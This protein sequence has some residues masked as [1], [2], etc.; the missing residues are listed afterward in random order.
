M[1]RDGTGAR[2][3]HGS[4]RIDDRRKP[5]GVP[6]QG[7]PSPDP[8]A[9]PARLR[10]VGVVLL[11]LYFVALGWYA[12]HA[13][14]MPWAYDGNLTPFASVRADLAVGGTDGL[15][16]IAGGLLGTAPLGVLLPMAGGRLRVSAVGSFLH[17]LGLSTLIAT[18]L[19][20]ARETLAGQ[21][22]DVDRVLL[23]VI[24]A[25]V[26][27]LAVVPAGRAVLRARLRR[28]R[29]VERVAA[30]PVVAPAPAAPAPE[31]APVVPRPTTA[32]RTCRSARRTTLAQRQLGSPPCVVTAPD[33]T[34]GAHWLHRA[35]WVRMRRAGWL[36]RARRPH[37]GRPAGTAPG[38]L[39]GGHRTIA[40]ARTGPALR[41]PVLA[42]ADL[43]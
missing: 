20:A 13:V 30:A 2:T 42:S 17:C 21:L 22:P 39:T 24:G 16:R 35:R 19:E 14:A 33:R 15:L 23:G 41:P 11:A 6:P 34:A 27:H 28:P 36:R 12:Q 43:R 40:P 38:R 4:V 9:L 18:A 29:R 1:Q 8:D 32:V 10:T 37:P 31:P 5:E 26:L 7:R 3:A 25:G